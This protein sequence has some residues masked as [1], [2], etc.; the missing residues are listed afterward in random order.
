M[1]TISPSGAP[2]CGQLVKNPRRFAGAHSPAMRTDPLHSP[3]TASPCT[4]RNSV[5]S[6]ALAGPIVAY[7][8][9]RPTAI[10]A[11]PISIIVVMRSDFLPTRSPK[12]PKS[13]APSGLATKPTKKVEN[14]RIWPTN[15]SELGKK[16]LGKTSAAADP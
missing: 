13:A 9:T 11:A 7:D 4:A 6:T 14:E 2:A 3:P 1:A 5:S 8:G 16:S 15:G 10:V 12:W